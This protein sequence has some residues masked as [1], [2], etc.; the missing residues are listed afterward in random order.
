[1]VS[2]RSNDKSG[3]GSFNPLFWHIYRLAM[4]AGRKSD[5]RE[6]DKELKP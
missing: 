5:E 4:E 6:A 3:N 1:M 2:S